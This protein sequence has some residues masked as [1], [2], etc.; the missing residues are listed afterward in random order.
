MKK[1]TVRDIVIAGVAALVAGAMSMAAGEYVSVSSQADAE[2]ADLAREKRELETNQLAEHK[3]LTEIYIE[4]GLEASLARQVAEQLMQHDALGA[5]ARDELGI[6][7]MT[8]A[9]PLLAAMSSALAF[10]MG[11]LTPLV[12]AVFTEGR[13]LIPVVA[14]VSLLCLATL[15]GLAARVGGGKVMRAA[16]RVTFWGALAMG[17]TAVIGRLFGVML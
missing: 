4:R 17:V 10:S 14:V 15:G 12:V 1:L 11:A 8:R 13:Y 6:S 2:A 7:D 5:H 3:E 16:F 9:R